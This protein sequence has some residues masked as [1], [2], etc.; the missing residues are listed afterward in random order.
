MLVRWCWCSNR[1]WQGPPWVADQTL[2]LGEVLPTGPESLGQGGFEVFQG[3]E[4]RVGEDPAQ[5]FEPA[6]RRIEFG[7]VGRQ[8]D[9]L[10]AVG[11]ADFPAGVAAAGV[12]HK[13]NPVGAGVPA[14]LLQ[15][16]FEAGP[17]DVRQE[18][19]EAGPADRLDCGV[20]PKPV[21]LVVVDPRRTAAE[22]APLPAMRGLQAACCTDVRDGVG[23]R[24]ISMLRISPSCR[25]KRMLP[26]ATIFRGRSDA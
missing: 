5:G 14:Q 25:T 24:S 22:R 9:L 1:S 23:G 4:H 12:E 18:Q 10:D 2:Q 21:V 8:R 17:V 11:P 19:H 7:A 26:A 6:L 16:A 20:Q 13:P 15:E 3:V